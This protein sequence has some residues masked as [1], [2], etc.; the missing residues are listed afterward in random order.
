MCSVWLTLCERRL[1]SCSREIAARES[2]M[3]TVTLMGARSLR[4]SA[5]KLIA[6]SFAAV[7][8]AREG[9]R[10]L[11]TAPTDGTTQAVAAE[12]SGSTYPSTQTSSRPLSFS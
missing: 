7:E 8:E 2:H 12:P 6:V 9:R 4:K 3:M 5:A 10:H 1:A 11:R